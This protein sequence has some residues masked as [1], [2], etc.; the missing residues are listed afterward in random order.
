[1]A[2]VIDFHSHVLEAEV[3]DQAWDHNV[4]SGFGAITPPPQI[5]GFKAKML[6]PAEHIVDMD[7]RG[8]DVEVVSSST[9][10][11]GCEWADP[12]TDLALNQRLNDAN[13]AA[14]QR[15]SGSVLGSITLPL[16]AP[17]LAVRELLRANEELGL[18]V[19]NMPANVKGTYVGHPS[20]WPVWE[21]VAERDLV[22]F[23]HPHGVKDPWYLDYGLWNSVGQTVEEARAISS[24]IYEG[25]LDHLPTLKIVISHGGGYLPH[26]CGR[27]DRNVH[28]MPHSARNITRL[29]SEYLRD[30]Y[31]DT[32]VYDPETLKALVGR[33]GVDRIVLGSDYPVGDPDPVGFV[34]RCPGLSPEQITAIKSSTGTRLLGLGEEQNRAL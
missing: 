7:K 4:M 2:P 31:F 25:L 20:L 24:M 33:V 8:I 29:P 14:Q 10:F 34:E 5:A 16:Q 3:A 1:M 32:C 27:L 26:Y 23:M 18:R 30:L 17:D 6:D 13:A 19:V 12:R 9:V 22:V 21:A 15:Y 11:A 28:N